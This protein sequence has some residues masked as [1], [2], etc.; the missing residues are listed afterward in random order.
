MQSKIIVMQV[1]RQSVSR[2]NRRNKIILAVVLVAVVIAVVVTV[3]VLVTRK[4]GEDTRIICDKSRNSDLPFCDSSLSFDSRIK[5]LI[6]RLTVE[7]KIGLLVNRA[8]GASVNVELSF[9]NWWNEALHGVADNTAVIGTFFRPPTEYS[10]V[11]PQIISLST[12]F[13]MNL[14]L[15]IANST[16][17]EARAFHNAGNADLTFWSPN[18]NIYRDPRWGRGQETPGEDPFLS[19]EYARMVIDGLQGDEDKVGYLK[20]SACCKHFAAH[21]LETD[22]YSFDAVVN[23]QDMADTYL[24]VFKT[25][26]ENKVTSIMTAYSGINGV[27]ATANKYYITDVIR[28]QWGFDGYI[29]S[30]CGAVDN[31]INDHK[32]TKTESE[33]CHAVLDAGVDIECGDFFTRS[34]YLQAAVSD[35]SVTEAMLDTALYRGFRVLMR[36]GY[37]EKDDKRPY[38]EFQP[39]DV[40][41]ETHRQLALDAARRSIVLLKNDVTESTGAP[42]LPLHHLDFA[43]NGASVA[44]IGPHVNASTVFLGNYHGIP[45]F[46]KVPLNEIQRYWSDVKWEAGCEV[47]SFENNRLIEAENLARSSSQVILFVGINTEIEGEFGDRH[48]ITFTGL[49]TDLIRRVLA[50]ALQPV[51]MVVVSGGAIDLSAYKNDPR[52]G[53]IVW[54]GYIGQSGG[55]AIADVLF[56]NYNPSGRLTQTFYDTNFL[57]QVTLQDMNMRPV[58]GSPGRTYRFFTGN[59][60][61]P[62]GHGL[63]YTSFQYTFASEAD[64]Q[65]PQSSSGCTY[66]VVRVQNIGSLPGDHSVLTFV[67]PP[68]AGLEGRPIKNLKD[69]Q[70]LHN[71]VASQIRDVQIC[72]NI[73]MFKLANLD[74]EFEV[75]LGEWTLMV[76]DIT[77]GI[78]IY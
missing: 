75:V 22:R 55:E 31:V 9:Y 60:V 62:F 5:D 56:G 37:F 58:N 71:V 77:K 48:N 24:P 46:I 19:A 47:D 16:G 41:S 34:G 30:D 76:G 21:S 61:Y 39:E 32:Y 36:L 20:V 4:S 15:Q 53:A 1:S 51:I 2:M 57:D 49:Q 12:S 54:A 7:E 38:K 43:S 18:I 59:P 8:A 3:V 52:V 11:F 33:N 10:T 13:D 17:N 70:K 42:P 44:L 28:G 69:F 65:I 50:V 25:C 64:V 66:V 73:D 72:L 6:S 74:G 27:P 67:A 78:V 23:K 40:D 68:N 26:V 29:V 35:G 63:S 14:Y 45:S